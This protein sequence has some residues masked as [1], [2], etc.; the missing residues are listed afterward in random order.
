[1]GLVILFPLT[2]TFGVRTRLL[3]ALTDLV[4]GP[5]GLKAGR[6]RI[7]TE[8]F[9]LIGLELLPASASIIFSRASICPLAIFLSVFFLP[10][11]C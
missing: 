3:I 6:L 10:I 1:M 9:P 2:P 7:N 4:I 5:S 11:N 8:S